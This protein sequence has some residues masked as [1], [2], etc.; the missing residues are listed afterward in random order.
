[1]ENLFDFFT[2]LSPSISLNSGENMKNLL[3]FSQKD[4]PAD[5]C[6]CEEGVEETWK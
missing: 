2:K 4:F 6:F 1:M 3:L 5:F